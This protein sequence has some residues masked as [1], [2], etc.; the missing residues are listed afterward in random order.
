MRA[1]IASDIH[2]DLKLLQKILEQDTEMLI[3]SGDLSN[4][5]SMIEIQVVLDKISKS[6][7]KYK[8][9]VF[10][11]HDIEAEFNIPYIKNK[12]KNIIFLNNEIVDIEGLKIYGTPYVKAF[13]FWGFQCYTSDEKQKYTVP[14]EEVDVI[15]THEPP[16]HKDLS[17]LPFN[18]DIGNRHLRIYIEETEK[19]KYII[20]GH[21]HENSRNEITLNNAKCYNVAMT[22]KNIE[23]N[24]E[25]Q[26]DI[27]H[28]D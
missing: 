20:C 4:R 28:F 12:Y 27:S 22:Y 2:M 19:V 7:F 10:G 16:S 26:C 11:N 8:I 23:I 13:C 15:V 6:K 1:T 18:E 14:T 17:Y 24:T 5:G 21:V 9:I 3:I 25:E